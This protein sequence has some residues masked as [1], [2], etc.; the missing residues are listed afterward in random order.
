MNASRS[1]H[2]GLG[3]LGGEARGSRAGSGS[4]AI[5]GSAARCPPSGSQCAGSEAVAVAETL[6]HALVPDGTELGGNLQL[7]ELLH[8]V[9]D[10]L[11]DKLPRGVTFQ[12][13]CQPGCGNMVYWH[14]L[15]GMGAT[16]TKETGLPA[17]CKTSLWAGRI[18]C[19]SPSDDA[20]V[21]A[22]GVLHHLGGRRFSLFLVFS[23]PGGYA[24]WLSSV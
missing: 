14:G 6:F 11:G 23:F 17:L 7:N 15:S 21:G 2:K 8:V 20:G 13:R 24:S 4:P 3:R 16:R 9:A 18:R 1:R 12:E 10:Q 5:S 19:G 22:P